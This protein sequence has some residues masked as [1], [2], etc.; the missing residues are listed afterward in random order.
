MDKPKVL[1]VQN[2]TR[3]DELRAML[4]ARREAMTSEIIQNSPALQVMSGLAGENVVRKL[5]TRR[6]KG[7]KYTPHQGNNEKWRRLKKLIRN[8]PVDCHCE[9]CELAMTL[10]AT[11]D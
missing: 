1:V 7:N 8:H 9:S 3:V 2:K 10:T 5:I 11:Q 6:V 4:D